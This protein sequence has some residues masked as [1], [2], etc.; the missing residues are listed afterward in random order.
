[1]SSQSTDPQRIEALEGASSLQLYQPKAIIEGM[2]DDPRRAIAARAGLYL[3]QA[4]EFV[5]FRDGQCAG[6]RL[7]R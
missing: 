3:G 7:L 5:D 4:V 6:A 2:L 1:M